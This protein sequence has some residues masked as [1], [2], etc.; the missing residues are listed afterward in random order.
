MQYQFQANNIH[1]KNCANTIK[2]SLEDDFGDIE[3]DLSKDPKVITVNLKDEKEIEDFK[4]QMKELGFEI[5][6]Q[7]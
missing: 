6:G 3:V 4:T 7:V 5:I 2:V 1:C